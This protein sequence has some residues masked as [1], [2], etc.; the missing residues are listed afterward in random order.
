MLIEALKLGAT[1]V[2]ACQYAGIA[3]TTF[4][5]WLAENAEFSASIE[6]A[7]S[8]AA[9]DALRT[10]QKA[11]REGQWQSAAWLL[12]RRYPQEYG[13]RTVQMEVTGKLDMNVLIKQIHEMDDEQLAALAEG[14]TDMLGAPKD[15]A[16]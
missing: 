6:K 10:I 1:N 2:L 9:I 14:K 4:Y 15:E 5:D 12:E 13:R 7:R 8:Y 16:E 3:E 11:R